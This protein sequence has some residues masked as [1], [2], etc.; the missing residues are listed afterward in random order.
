MTTELQVKM[1]TISGLIHFIRGEKVILDVDL[2]RLYEAP[3]KVLKQAVRRNLSRFPADFMIEL[4]ED[5][6]LS[7]RSQIVTSKKG[8]TKYLPFAFTEQGVAMLSSVL[9]SEKAIEVNI[10]IM[11]AF[12]QMRKFFETNKELAEKIEELERTVSSHD[13]D[14]LLIFETI[15]QLM[16]KKNQPMEPV[17][18][19]IPQVNQS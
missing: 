10:A 16:H 17:G 6:A 18:F 9:N 12:V 13:E 15:K 5:E 4:T 19:K 2:A 3:T 7:L 8:G 14:I 11:R 1:E